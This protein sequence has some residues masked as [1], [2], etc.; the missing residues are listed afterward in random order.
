MGASPLKIR[1]DMHR[2]G[3]GFFNKQTIDG[4]ERKHTRL[5]VP[6]CALLLPKRFSE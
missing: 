3:K 4:Q 6:K 1:P 5:N 2:V